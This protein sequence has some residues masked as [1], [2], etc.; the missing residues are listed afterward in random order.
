MVRPLSAGASA[1]GR[2]AARRLLRRDDAGQPP[3]HRPAERAGD[4]DHAERDERAPH[5]QGVLG[6]GGG[7]AGAAAGAVPGTGARRPGT[8]RLEL[9]AIAADRVDEPVDQPQ[10]V[11][12]RR[13]QLLFVGV[14]DEAELDQHRRHVG[15]DEHAERRLLDRPRAH[16]HARPQRL[17]D[18]AGDHRRLLE[19]LE[20]R[21]L[22]EHHLDGAIAAGRRRQHRAF[23]LGDAPG[24]GA[25]AVEAEEEDLGAGRLLAHRGVQVQAD[26]QIGLVVVG[27]GGALVEIDGAVVLAR[28]QRA[29][30]EPRLERALEQAGDGQRDVLLEGPGGAAGAGPADAF[31][32]DVAA[33]SGIDDDGVDRRGFGPERG[34]GLGARCAG[35]RR[36]PRRGCPVCRGRRRGLPGGR[37]L[38]GEDLDGGAARRPVRPF[39]DAEGAVARALIDGHR[40]RVGQRAQR[41][42]EIRRR[43]PRPARDRAPSPRSARPAG[44]A[45]RRPC[46]ASTASRR[47]GRA[48]AAAASR[49]GPGRAARARRRRRSGA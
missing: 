9:G 8:A 3:E 35:R 26:E 7:D 45:R 38:G 21:H 11:G 40:R 13:E 33:V 12:V 22:P 43:R 25:V 16:L 32:V 23:H 41:E 20:L 42:H 34:R 14:R 2:P 28:Q 17:L 29:H 1:D 31:D 47:N 24:L 19:V 6:A 15:A 49:A 36:L 30:A 4:E 39:D 18:Q 44:R 37:R 48:P 5:G 46:A 10:L 27:E